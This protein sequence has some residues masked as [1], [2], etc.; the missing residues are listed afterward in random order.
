MGYENPMLGKLTNLELELNTLLG[1]YSPDHY[2]VKQ[3]NLKIENLKKAM[4]SEIKK[5]I[6]EKAVRHTLVKNPIRESL[7][8]SIIDQTIEISVLEAKRIAL[9][10]INEKLNIQ[11]SKI[12]LIE[13]EYGHLQRETESLLKTLRMLKVK[14]EEA[15]IK[16]DSKESEL[17]ILEL[18]DIPKNA[19]SR[20]KFSSIYINIIIGIIIGIALAFL[21]EYIDQSIKDPSAV[22]K[23]LELPL[24]GIVPMIESSNTVVDENDFKKSMLEPFRSLRA[25]IKYIANQH[26]AKLFMVC[27]AI[28][29]EGKT[30]LTT[31]LAIA[32]AMDGKKTIIVD[33]D[34]RRSQIHTLLNIPKD[35]GLS[36]YILDKKSIDK[37]IKPTRYNNLFA[38]TSGE[39]P[40]NPA[41]LLGT[42]KFL[43]VLNELRKKADIILLDSPAIIPVS[44]SM[45]MAPYMDCCLMITRA[46]WTPV[47]A[48]KQAKNQLTRIKTNVIGCV[49][50]GLSHSRGYYPYYYGYYGYYAYKYTYDYDE[51]PKKKT[52]RELGLSFDSFLKSTIQ[53][54]KMKIQRATVKCGIIISDISKRIAFW[55]LL[56]TL[57]SL[58]ITR[59]YLFPHNKKNDTSITYLGQIYSNKIDK[60]N[61]EGF[62]LFNFFSGFS[63][64]FFKLTSEKEELDLNANSTGVYSAV[65]YKGYRFSFHDSIAL[66]KNAFNTSQEKRFLQ[67]YDQKNFKF[68]GGKYSEW[69]K[70]IKIKLLNNSNK[71][72]IISLKIKAIEKVRSNYYQTIFNTQIHS[73][74]GTKTVMK[75]MIWKLNNNRWRIIREKDKLLQ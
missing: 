8:Q 68:P 12:P 70:I 42:P 46:F 1:E 32:F 60:Q 75:T 73:N 67:F 62:D 9:E 27:S 48:A 66:W 51:T 45:T 72:S 39:R 58:F 15:K 44:D 61:K 56:L 31:N 40:N 36:D 3:I 63:D 20:K 41:E 19:I 57:T 50:N 59:Q 74:N 4:Q 52:F 25:N 2:K 34:L 30:T 55:I 43:S 47:K 6:T 28:K 10:Q 35:I 16:R 71:Y 69:Q 33:A 37:I 64:S 17:K 7:L 49:L 14:Y 54:G 23:L 24:I 21:F 53:T 22:E 65:S 5:E 18:A 26:K 38:I 11:M 13:Q 29:G